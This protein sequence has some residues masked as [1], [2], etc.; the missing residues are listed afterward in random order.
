MGEGTFSYGVRAYCL[1][2][3]F[4]K[5]DI[6]QNICK[7]GRERHLKYVGPNT[8][9][10]IVHYTHIQTMSTMYKYHITINKYVL[11]KY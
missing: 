5:G 7:T 6:M 2:T 11:T 9:S 10:T 1:Y 8:G 3:V 4:E